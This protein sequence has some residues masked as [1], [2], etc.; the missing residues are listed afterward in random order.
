[1]H[2]ATH[3]L[4]WEMRHFLTVSFTTF[5]DEEYLFSRNFQRLRNARC[6]IL[7][8]AK[9][10][11]RL[12][13]SGFSSLETDSRHFFPFPK[14]RFEMANFLWNILN[15]E[16][17]KK[18]WELNNRN[19]LQVWAG[20]NTFLSALYRREKV[21]I[22]PVFEHFF[23]TSIADSCEMLLR[24]VDHFQPKRVCGCDVPSWKSPLLKYFQPFLETS[25]TDWW[26]ILFR[27]AAQNC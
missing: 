8:D 25:I 14:Q 23:E 13:M 20:Q 5:R 1:M 9:Q 21:R 15:F 22:W 7:A 27:D 16:S 3:Q 4:F 24:D 10:G 6:A 12:Q 2:D 18:E 11:R 17:E 19:R 26:E